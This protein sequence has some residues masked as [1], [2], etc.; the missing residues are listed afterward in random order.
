MYGH[1][2]KWTQQPDGKWVARCSCG[3]WA[4]F[5]KNRGVIQRN[6]NRKHIDKIK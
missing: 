5:G 1:T 6:W 3:G 2:L 4:G